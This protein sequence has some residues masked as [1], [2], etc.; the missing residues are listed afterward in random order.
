MRDVVSL[1]ATR[2]SIDAGMHPPELL[3]AWDE[4]TIDENFEGW[5]SAC[6]AAL[7]A[8]GGDLDQHRYITLRVPEDVLEEAFFRTISATTSAL[9]SDEHG[10]PLGA[11]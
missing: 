7:S 8:M 3:V 4:Y 10:R 2:K 5:H 6:M 9:V 1:W 11:S